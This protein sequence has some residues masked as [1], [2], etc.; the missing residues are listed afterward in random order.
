MK[1]QTIISIN[2]SNYQVIGDF[3]SSTHQHVTEAI[4]QARGA[5]A[6]WS[7]APLEH[8]VACLERV[9]QEFLRRKDD[10]RILMAQEMGMPIALCDK[11]DIDP[12]FHYLRGYMDYAQEWLASEVIYKSVDEIHYLFYEPRGVVGVSVPWNY[13]FSNFIWGVMQNLIVGNTVVCKHS[14]ETILTSKLYAEIMQA[15]GVPTGV[16]TMVY[17]TGEDVGEYLMQKNL[18]AI[19]F[20]GS[21]RVG[22]HLYQVAAQKFIPAILEL[23]GSSAGIVFEDVD[24][25]T[26]VKSLYNNRFFNNGQTC[27]GLKRLIVHHTLFDTVVKQLA[28]YTRTK[29]IGP[30]DD[31]TTDLGPL[32]AERQV[33]ALEAQVADALKKGAQIIIGGKRPQNLQGAYYEPTI[34]VNITRDMEVW[35][36]EVFGPVLPIVSFT[37]EEEAIKLANDSQYGLGGYIYTKDNERAVRVSRQLQTGNCMVND[38]NYNRPEDPFGGYKNSGLGRE[39]GKAGLRELMQAK[40]VAFKK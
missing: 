6:S 35:K 27:D 37:T 5:F 19:W 20:T 1:A 38:A 29:K 21:T 7:Q 12:G 8:R 36:E 15:A 14:E 24:V 31:P 23:G 28:T 32:V 26:I 9:Y 18:D 16:F 4:A 17:G 34:L 2:P 30:A 22:K 39:H 33:E 11:L 40:V 25:P 13:P 3:S 10:L